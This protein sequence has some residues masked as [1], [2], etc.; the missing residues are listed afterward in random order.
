MEHMSSSMRSHRFGGVVVSFV[1]KA[2]RRYFSLNKNP[3]LCNGTF[4]CL[5]AF[6][7]NL[8][9]LVWRIHPHARI[10]FFYLEYG[11]S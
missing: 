7:G 9:Y 3:L 5:L 2:N 11:R 8:C 10:S 4:Q 1:F 6:S